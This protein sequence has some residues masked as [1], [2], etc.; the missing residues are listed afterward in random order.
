VDRVTRVKAELF[1]SLG[2][3]GH[4]HGSAGAVVLG[5]LGERPETVDN[6]R[7]PALLEEIGRRHRLAL[8][9]RHEIDFVEADDLVLYR[10]RSLPGHPN[11]MIFRAFAGGT[12]V[13]SRTYYPVGGG[14]V[15]G[16]HDP[17]VPD[18]T[19]Q[20]HPFATAD[21]LLA[22][23]AATRE[24]ISGIM[25]RNESVWR[26]DARIDEDL[27]GIWAAMQECVCRGG[28]RRGI[29]PA[30]RVAAGAPPRPRP[31]RT[32]GGPVGERRP[33]PRDGLGQSVRDL[34]ERGERIRRPDRDRSDQRRGRGHPCR[35]A[36]LPALRPGELRRGR[37]PVPAHR[38][39]HRARHQAERVDLAE[40]GCQG[41]V[42]SACP[43][44]AAGLTEV[45][46]GTPEQVENAAEI[47]IEHHLGLT[48]DPVGGL[49]Q[50]P[51]I[52]RN[53]VAATKAIHAGRMALHGDGRHVVSLDKAIKTMR[54][55]GADMK[56]KYNETAR[57]GLAV[58][59]IEC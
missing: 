39:R 27:L 8:A 13:A 38:G 22:Q 9:G 59:V 55:T 23:C 52:E 56:V 46:G 25:R 51:C 44:A 14:F 31:A 10:R 54:D 24:P 50:I 57:G 30:A 33:A 18:E 5:L 6:D 35:A 12:E 28:E 48:C 3:T 37:G 49:V 42:G 58:N 16:E 4:G 11:G 45:L 36:L 43:M 32:P 29:L 26:T 40:V 19:A 17:V 53:A 34:R 47:G 15:R 2:A 7:V 41:E 20:P 1:G 21:E